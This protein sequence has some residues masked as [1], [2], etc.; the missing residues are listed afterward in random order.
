VGWPWLGCDRVVG[1]GV[2]V[3]EP[4]G[5]TGA[6][7]L[8]YALESNTTSLSALHA[9]AWQTGHDP[10]GTHIS[11]SHSP[12]TLSTPLAFNSS[13]SPAPA[14]TPCS[15]AVGPDYRTA[16]LLTFQRMGASAAHFDCLATARD[17]HARILSSCATSSRS[18]AQEASHVAGSCCA[19]TL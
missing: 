12:R 17:L 19:A 10:Q 1:L 3:G 4:C 7:A 15:C 11:A 13:D 9:S 16:T 18:L 8:D 6:A 5:A 14:K 2:V